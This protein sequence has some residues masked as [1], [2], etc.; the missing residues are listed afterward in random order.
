MMR[1]SSFFK[2]IQR[3]DSVDDTTS[4]TDQADETVAI[5]H[6]LSKAHSSYHHI[7]KRKIDEMR[8]SHRLQVSST[9]M[10]VIYLRFVLFF[11]CNTTRLFNFTYRL[12]K[13]LK[14]PPCAMYFAAFRVTT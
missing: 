9:K 14:I 12:F 3:P 2:T 6:L 4:D 8:F 10:Q 11:I 1:L 13:P 5:T 7:T